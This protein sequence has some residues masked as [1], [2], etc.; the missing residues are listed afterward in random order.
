MPAFYLQ[1][2]S[3]L[4]KIPAFKTPIEERNPTVMKKI[5][6]ATAIALALLAPATF[7]RALVTEG[8]NE[9]AISGFFDPETA[10]GSSV[11]FNLRY[12]YFFWDYISIGLQGGISDNDAATAGSIGLTGEYNFPISDDYE[13]LIGTDFVP[14]CGGAV[15][16]QHAEIYNKKS[17][18]AVFTG[19]VGMK[20][21][22]TDTAA[23]TTS[24]LSSIATEDVYV[25]DKDET[26][27][28]LSLRLG[29]RF[30]F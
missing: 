28:D 15:S 7:A 16:Y 24:F 27:F 9:I 18:A 30:Y 13:A 26:N 10:V 19:E 8:S 25:D 2:T 11:D 5:L 1:S 21:F 20:F 17:D 12:A 6:V 22:L 14:Y 29:M 3:G 4:G 23:V